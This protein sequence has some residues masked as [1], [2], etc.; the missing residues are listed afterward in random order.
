MCWSSLS[1]G[2]ICLNSGNMCLIA[3][4]IDKLLHLAIEPEQTEHIE[5]YLKNDGNPLSRSFLVLFY[6]QQNRVV[7]AIQLQSSRSSLEVSFL[8]AMR[9]V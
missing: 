7:D 9:C 4:Q 2:N 5:S 8:R 6:L 1:S 3:K